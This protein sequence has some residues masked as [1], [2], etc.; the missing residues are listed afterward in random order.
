MIQLL[1]SLNLLLFNNIATDTYHGQPK[2]SGEPYRPVVS[3]A[4]VLVRLIYVLAFNQVV[5]TD[6]GRMMGIPRARLITIWETIPI[7]REMLNRTV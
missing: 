1:L 5:V 2:R 6:F 7:A 3:K 4:V